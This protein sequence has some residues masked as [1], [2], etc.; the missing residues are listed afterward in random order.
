MLAHRYT[1]SAAP[2]PLHPPSLPSLICWVGE[3]G[4]LR[5]WRVQHEC[6]CRVVHRELERAPFGEQEVARAR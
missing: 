1:R 2:A 3:L 4:E 6:V 5:T